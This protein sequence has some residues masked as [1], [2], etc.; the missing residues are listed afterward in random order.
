MWE[1]SSAD[2]CDG[3]VGP[4]AISFRSAFRTAKE[5]G[6]PSPHNAWTIA[7]WQRH[8]SGSRNRI[9]PVVR[10]IQSMAHSSKWIAIAA[11]A[12]GHDTAAKFDCRSK[13]VRIVYR[14]S[15]WSTVRVKMQLL[16]RSADAG[17][18]NPSAFPNPTV[19]CNCICWCRTQGNRS[20]TRNPM[21]W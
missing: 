18:L 17:L 5:R 7:I 1:C 16:R 3:T 9:C 12:S 19:H 13:R 11:T 4:V 10:I 15:A 2:R 6:N 21:M 20:T 8:N 14:R